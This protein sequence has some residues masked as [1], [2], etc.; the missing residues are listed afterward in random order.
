MPTPKSSCAG[1]MAK[2]RRTSAVITRELDA[3]P[4][5]KVDLE[6]NSECQELLVHYACSRSAN[7][8]Q[9]T[10]ER[11]QCPAGATVTNITNN[12]G[13]H[14][15]TTA[16]VVDD[17]LLNLCE[18]ARYQHMKR[19]RGQLRKLCAAAGVPKVP[20]LA[21]ERWL[22]RAQLSAPCQAPGADPVLPM[23]GGTMLDHG[24]VRDLL[25]AGCRDAAAAEGVATALIDASAS[26]AAAVDALR[27]G[28]CGAPGQPVAPPAVH[29]EHR[30]QALH[31]SL[32]RDT[33]PFFKLNYSHHAKLR[34]MWLAHRHSNGTSLDPATEEYGSSRSAGSDSAGASF[35]AAVWRLLA[36]YDSIGG[37]GFQ[38]AVGEA[39]FDA[40]A[41][42]LSVNWECFASPLNCRFESGYCSAFPDTDT[43]FGS[44]GSFLRFEAT[45]GHFEANPPFVPEIMSAMTAHIH[46]LL[47]KAERLGTALAF[48]VLIPKWVKVQAWG[49]LE[50]SQWCKHSLCLSAAD[51]GFFDGA[52][53]HTALPTPT[54]G[55]FP[56]NP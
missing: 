4:L 20:L 17:D 44:V 53:H 30:R 3:L 51:H 7:L 2:R 46:A 37:A 24:M 50:R 41:N 34:R 36:R 18:L 14:N 12:N 47:Q 6:K 13:N 32:G 31:F 11:Q 10:E 48:V 27:K 5:P 21:F 19:L 55:A 26:A 40:L 39:G 54:T 23:G 35:D 33:K 25:R 38:A 28:G 49:Q 29:V 43:P 15:S 52:Q 16:Q 22:C 42:L 9:I 8:Q 1:L 56:Y 45:E